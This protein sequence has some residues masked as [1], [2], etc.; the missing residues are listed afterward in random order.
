MTETQLNSAVIQSDAPCASLGNGANGGLSAD[1]TCWSIT[2]YFIYGL[3]LVVV[4]DVPNHWGAVYYGAKVVLC[5]LLIST[6]LLPV[7]RA[8][9][10]LFLLA[11][12]GQDIVSSG[13]FSDAFATASVWQMSFG[14][15]RPS[16]LMFGCLFVLLIKI[17]FQN[18]G[19]ITAPPLMRAAMIWFVTVPIITGIFYGG[20][21][22]EHAGV[23]VVKDLKFGAMFIGSTL[24]FLTVL[25]KYPDQLPLF[26]SAFIGVLLA[27]HLVDLIY[28]FTNFGPVI[29]EGVSRGSEDS[30][31][32]GVIFLVYFGLM[33]VFWRKRLLLGSAISVLTVLL[34]AAYGTRM[35]WITFLLGAVVLVFLVR[36]HQ[37][38]LLIAIMILLTVGG[39]WAL[40][41]VN[42]ESAQVVLAR[43]VMVTHGRDFHKF[44]VPADYNF[45][46]RIDPI[47]YGEMLNILHGA[48]KRVAY[49]WGTGYGGFYEDDVINMPA[50]LISSFPQYSL[51][52]GEFYRAHG[53]LMHIFLKH[54]LVGLFLISA[55][56]L[57]PGYALFRVFRSRNMLAGD[58]PTMVNGVMLCMV[59]FI[60]TAMLQLYWSGKGL[61]INGLIVA[62]CLEFARRNRSYPNRALHGNVWVNPESDGA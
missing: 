44:A 41:K 35:L 21:L 27:R 33:L 52:K 1:I 9:L 54:G 12:A 24:L 13:N 4:S 28:I 55:L 47:R 39:P 46:S 53:F 37:K 62:S 32:G 60:A 6:F 40:Y 29:A 11:V 34:L 15:I 48:D 56:W 43:L 45:I 23:E 17:T 49:L 57:I 18:L 5:V 22:T 2:K 50:N 30:A 61:F 16:W 59:A 58:Q 7:R 8:L 31:K 10:L 19:S 14:P 42:P 20:F 36:S 25:R 3:I 26:L 51:D 38:M